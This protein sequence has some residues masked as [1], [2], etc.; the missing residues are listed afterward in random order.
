LNYY[1]EKYKVAIQ[2]LQT[3]ADADDL[4]CLDDAMAIA[5]K[6]L[7]YLIEPSIQYP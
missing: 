6:T 3:I 7:D 2:A 1:V 5:R 4:F